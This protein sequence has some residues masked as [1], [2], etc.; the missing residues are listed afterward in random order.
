MSYEH[1]VRPISC[2]AP[3]LKTE[4]N[5]FRIGPKD[6]SQKVFMQA[7]LHADEQPGIMILHHLLPMLKQ[8]DT[9]GFLNT[10]FVIF[11]MV[12]PLGMS[13]LSFG[14]HQGRYNRVTGV[15]FN[16]Q[17]PDLYKEIHE[18]VANK[19]TNNPDKNI[20]I[21]RNEI[22]QWLAKSKPVTAI[23]QQQHIVIEEAFDAD[24]VLDLH[25]DNDS[26]AHIFSVPQSTDVMQSLSDWMGAAAT[27]MAKDSGGH[28]FDEVWSTVWLKLA[29]TYPDKPIPLACHS[30]T[31]EYRGR[32][33][34]FDSINL[35]D[36][37]RLY[38]FLQA[39]DL[40]KGDLIRSKPPATAKPTDLAATEFTKVN[41]AGLL[42][43]QVELGDIVKKGDVLADLIALDGDGAF[44]KRTPILAGTDGLLLSR[45]VQKYV[46]PGCN[47]AKV[48]G[49]KKLTS[50]NG[51]LL[52]D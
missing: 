35:D 10:E 4:L 8:A 9:N 3:G 20:H 15:N 2:D 18:K 39:Q 42:A 26:L 41:E 48:V 50:R 23:Q 29:E 37:E 12:N 43:Y 34:V 1:I 24:Y 36:A 7:A 22:K 45:N 51:M 25:C 31:L 32:F 17:W 14:Q 52:A 44:S 28:S 19:L 47:I 27:L 11:P 38:G 46:W 6:A 49:T 33:D 5:Y 40:I 16:R 13:D 30:A 21:V